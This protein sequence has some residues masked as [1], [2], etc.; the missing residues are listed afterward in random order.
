MNTFDEATTRLID[1]TDGDV[2]AHTPPTPTAADEL[3]AAKAAQAAIISAARTV[4]G[5]Q[6]VTV[7]KIPYDAGPQSQK[8]ASGK[9][10]ASMAGQVTFPT[11][12]RDANNKTQ[13]LSQIQFANMAT[14][15]YAQVE[16]VY[17]KSFALKDA[18]EAAETIEDVQA[19]NWS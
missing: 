15:I 5:S 1:S 6:P 19:I 17:G 18:I 8:N 4:A 13:S 7:N 2:Y 9:M 16:E 11:Q 12:W 10:V 14:A 3:A